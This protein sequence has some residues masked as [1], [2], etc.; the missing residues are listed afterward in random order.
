M[1]HSYLKYIFAIFLII[2]LT[3]QLPAEIQE[4]LS[5]YQKELESIHGQN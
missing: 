2:L 4:N 1:K 5:D 3:S